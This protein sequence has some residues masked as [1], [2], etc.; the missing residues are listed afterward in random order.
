MAGCSNSALK[1]WH[2]A[3]LGDD[4]EAGRQTDSFA[5]YLEAE[6]RA[7]E[8]LDKEVYAKIETGPENAL[9]R[10]SRGS[11]SDPGTFPKNYNRTYELKAASPRGGVLLL[12]GMSDSPYSL[13]SIAEALN[14]AGLSVINLRLPGHGTAPAALTRAH[15]K[16]FAAAAELAMAQLQNEVGSMQIHI[17]GFSNGAPVA[18]NYALD[19]IEDPA[20]PRAASLILITPA[21][22]VSS[23]AWFAGFKN[24]LGGIPGLEGLRYSSINPE[25]EPFRY[26]SFPTNG[27]TQTH[28]LTR[29]V[30]K[31]VTKLVRNG[32]GESMPPVLV[33]TSAVD[34][35]VSNDAVIDR[36]LGRLPDNGNELIVF[37]VNRLAIKSSL[38]IEDPGPFA[39]RVSDAPALPFAVTLVRNESSESARVIASTKPAFSGEFAHSEPL[40]TSWPLGVASLSHIAL[41]FP[42]DDPLYGQYEPAEGSRLFL[43]EAILRG[44]RGILRI[45]GNWFTRQ[46]YN[47][48]YDYMEARI[49]EWCEE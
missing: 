24:F 30:N 46:R 22:G 16:D 17:V 14:A 25:F 27:A 20:L 42:P 21:I 15:W 48:F 7:F 10:Y 40:G 35:T 32:R 29:R 18:L 4:F 3:G 34:A 47:P 5:D 43:G 31:A 26:G 39:R 37:D 28:R 11:L 19:A 13:W 6:Q 12:H 1:P 2:T 49:L 9:N 36:L 38:I 44:E 45:P 8:E 33:I 23:A 41:T